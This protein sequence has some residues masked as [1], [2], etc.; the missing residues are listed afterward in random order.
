M[1]PAAIIGG[2]IIGGIASRSAADEVSDAADNA[3]GIQQQ[4][5]WQTR[6]DTAPWREA[7]ERALAQQEELISPEGYQAFEESLDPDK[8]KDTDYYKFLQSE[9]VRARDRSASSRG[10]L[11]SGG[12]Q[13]A[14][15]AFGQG[16][17]STEYGNYFQRQRALRTSRANE[18]ASVA[19]TG[20]QT[21]VQT[22]QLGQQ[23]AAGQANTILS[24]GQAQGAGILGVGNAITGGINQW[25]LGTGAGVG[26]ASADLDSTMSGTGLF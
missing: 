4:Q 3:T 2:A 17:A 11:L 13:R 20:Q 26:G 6:R 22:A 15:T 16:L 9:G 25:M 8:F 19:G 18:L 21:A 24:A 10:L 1:P 5:Y 12:Q 23:S 7:G 14:I